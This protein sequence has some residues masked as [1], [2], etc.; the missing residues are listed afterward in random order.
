[1]N[2][3]EWTIAVIPSPQQSDFISFGA[4]SQFQLTTLPLAKI[5]SHEDKQDIKVP[6]LP[7]VPVLNNNKVTFIMR[8]P[9]PLKGHVS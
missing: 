5:T 1:M 4:L 8:L 6:L 7:N 9:S 2:V 3:T